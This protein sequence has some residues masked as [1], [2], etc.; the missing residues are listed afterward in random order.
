MEHDV[1]HP[2]YELMI[3][4]RLDLFM[5]LREQP[6]DDDARPENKSAT[7]RRLVVMFKVSS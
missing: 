2:L 7:K 4:S 1:S 5:T 3:E 6:K